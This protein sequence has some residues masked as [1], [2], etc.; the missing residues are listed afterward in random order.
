MS[1]IF[2]ALSIVYIV[3]CVGL[4]T[5]ILMQRKRQAGLGA[6]LSGGAGAGSGNSGGSF[7][8]KNKKNTVEGKLETYTKVGGALF[9]ALSM[10]LG[11]LA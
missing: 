6:G 1:P 11:L 8:D 7:W 5:I 3:L 4:I 10:A 2:I 9:F